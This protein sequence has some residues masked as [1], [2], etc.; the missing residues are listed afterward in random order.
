MDEEIRRIDRHLA[1]LQRVA[2]GYEKLADHARK[3]RASHTF[4]SC[5]E[6]AGEAAAASLEQLGNLLEIMWELDR[7]ELE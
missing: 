3:D 6:A 2:W 1:K 5:V 7:N 4:R